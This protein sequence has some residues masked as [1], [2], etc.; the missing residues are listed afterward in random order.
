M[1]YCIDHDYHLHSRL[2]SCSNDP[3]QTVGALL[4]YGHQ[5]GLERLVLTDHFWDETIPGASPWYKKQNFSHIRQVLPLPQDNKTA[6]YF[7]CEGD[8]DKNGVI[9]ISPQRADTF[10]FIVLPTTHL[11]MTG[12]TIDPDG[13]GTQQRAK[14]W[15][16]RLE[17]LLDSSLPLRKVGLAHLTCPLIDKSTHDG[18]LRVL[19]AIEDPRLGDLFTRAAAAGIGIELNDNPDRYDDADLPRLYRPYRIA[20]E[21]GCRFYLGSDAHHP[22][23]LE[24]AMHRFKIMIEALELTENDKYH[25]PHEKK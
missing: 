12:F 16:Q 21:C 3:A 22:K 4:R 5:N 13:T 8:M 11:H 24:G 25:F 10:D 23:E 20:K 15:I 19:D 2:S 18:A 6:L 9:G 7:G 1:N 14:L 17:W